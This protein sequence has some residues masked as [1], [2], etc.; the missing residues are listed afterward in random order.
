LPGD[1]AFLPI[2]VFLAVVVIERI[3]TRREK[4]AI[5]KKLNMV[6]GAFYRF[7][8]GCFSS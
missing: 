2:E 6:V 1:I 8:V 5:I 4:L 3:F 7:V